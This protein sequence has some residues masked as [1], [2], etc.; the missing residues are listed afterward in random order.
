MSMLFIFRLL[1]FIT[2]W[3]VSVQLKSQTIIMEKKGGVYYVPCKVNG[4]GLKFI[5]DTGAGDVSISYAEAIFMLKN[6][7]LS[8][9]DLGGSQ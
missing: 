7:Y 2:L 5:F 9:S 4:L 1:G 3:L 8:E 6:G